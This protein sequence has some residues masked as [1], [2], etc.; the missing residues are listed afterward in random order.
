LFKSEEQLKA[1][2]EAF[3]GQGHI[4]IVSQE[5]ANKYLKKAGGSPFAT[6]LYIPHPKD[7]NL[8]LPIN[9]YDDE[10]KAEIKSE[11]QEILALLKAKSLIFAQ[12]I[13][14]EVTAQADTVNPTG[15]YH[16]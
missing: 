8:L 4:Q 9:G 2:M 7:N 6:G 15:S 12:K 13:S 11:T 14:H 16:T 5:T 1:S 3:G 10:I